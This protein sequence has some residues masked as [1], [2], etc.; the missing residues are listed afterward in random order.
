MLGIEEKLSQEIRTHFIKKHMLLLS[1]A[2]TKLGLGNEALLPINTFPRSSIH[3]S[4]LLQWLRSNLN[5]CGL[6]LR[7]VEF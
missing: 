1:G 7:Q 3:T 5:C 4:V 2:C 6:P